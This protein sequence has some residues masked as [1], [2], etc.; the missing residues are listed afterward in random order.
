MV[1]APR[2]LGRADYLG[3]NFAPGHPAVESPAAGPSQPI[4]PHNG[5][6]TFSP[7]L[8]AFVPTCGAPKRR[9]APRRAP[10][11]LVDEPAQNIAASDLRTTRPLSPA[12]CPRSGSSTCF[13]TRS[14]SRSGRRGPKEALVVALAIASDGRK[15]QLHLAVGNKESESCWTSFLPPRARPR[16][17]DADHRD[18]RRGAGARERGASG[19]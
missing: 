1:G 3:N 17:S 13:A 10:V 2:L 14:S 16:P 9:H 15:H 4:T 7:T 18:D 12:T 11:V 19:L 8:P 6:I 5:Q